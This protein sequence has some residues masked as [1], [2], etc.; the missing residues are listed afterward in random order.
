MFEFV[1]VCGSLCVHSPEKGESISIDRADVLP[2]A[3]IPTI[4]GLYYIRPWCWHL[5][6]CGT[7]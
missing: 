1:H 4:L 5:I 7:F 6:Y 3:P 2:V